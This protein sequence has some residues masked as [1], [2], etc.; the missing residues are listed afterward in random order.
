MCFKYQIGKFPFRPI[1]SADENNF[2]LNLC[3]RVVTTLVSDS[4][5]NQDLIADYVQFYQYQDVLFFTIR[6]LFNILDRLESTS[7]SEQFLINMFELIHP[8]RLKT[9]L[10]LLPESL[11]TKAK[12][13]KKQ[14]K[15]KD[16]RLCELQ[17]QASKLVEG[18][19][20][21]PTRQFAFDYVRDA[22]FF[23][24]LLVA[25]LR[26]QLPPSIY[27]RSLIFIDKFALQ[28]FAQPL[29]LADFLIASFETGGIIS[30]CSLS[31]L[32][33]LM[34]KCNLEY[35]NFYHQLYKLLTPAVTYAN[36]RA[37][38]LF[39]CDLFLTSSHISAAIVASFVKK[40]ARLALES[41]PDTISI[42]LPFIGNLLIR[43]PTIQTMMVRFQQTDPMSDPFQPDETNPEL[44]K[45]ID[46]CLW[47]LNLLQNHFVS[48][49]AK[50]AKQIAT[51]LPKFE[52]NLSEVFETNLD[53]VI[54]VE[55]K[56][57]VQT[58]F[59]YDPN[60]DIYYLL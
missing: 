24:K 9:P 49:I 40:L 35:Q 56:T 23:S 39:W 29:E 25:F 36:H 38:F 27:K 22:R 26:H 47:E 2:P 30:L 32:Y 60:C 6:T 58:K 7:L 59:T 31:P 12:T 48:S 46:S 15:N 5:S 34:G 14:K 13:I 20:N 51:D 33:I 4:K 19:K 16:I 10:D 21:L 45:A 17:T 57:L 52:W 1:Q 50:V 28:H 37:Q 42:V 44:T 54:E 11:R 8:I 53:D 18:E 3:E 55:A 43:H 41:Q